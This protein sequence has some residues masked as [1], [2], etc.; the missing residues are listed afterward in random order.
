V[1]KDDKMWAMFAHLSGLIA[2]ALGGMAFLGPLIIW[3]IQKDKSP[4]V[5]EQA[6][7]ALNFQI[8]LTIAFVASFVP[9]CLFPPAGVLTI[10]IYI[11]G[12]VMSIIAAMKA[13]N[14]EHYKYPVT[15]RFIN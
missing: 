9:C 5:A 1:S 15:L 6:K 10:G 2:S 7:E 14:G 12:L 8:T 11:F 3:L 13:N 4:F